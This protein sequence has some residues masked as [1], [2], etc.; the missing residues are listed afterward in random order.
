[1]VKMI[2]L[3]KIQKKI[4]RLHARNVVLGKAKVDL[5]WVWL[6]L[7]SQNV[8]LGKAIA[9]KSGFAVGVACGSAKSVLV[10]IKRRS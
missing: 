4:M 1:M 2:P 6:R 9:L 7:H 3:I 5:L 8:V 10:A